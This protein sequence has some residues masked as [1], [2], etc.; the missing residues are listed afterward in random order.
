VGAVLER[1][2]DELREHL[3]FGRA[4]L[5]SY[6]AGEDTVRTVVEQGPGLGPDEVVPLDGFPLL[7][8]ALADRRAVV[9]GD[10]RGGGTLVAAPLLVEGRCLGFA[11]ADRSGGELAL[12]ERELHLLTTLGLVAGILIEKASQQLALEDAVEELRRLDQVKSEFISIA[13]H[14]LRAPIAVVHGIAA[15][16]HLRGDQ[17]TAEQRDE[18]RSTMYAQTGKLR[19]LTE[20]LLDLSRIDSGALRIEPCRFRPRESIDALL[21]RIAP[22]RLSDVEVAIDPG[23][24]VETDPNGFERVTGNLIGNALKYGRPPVVVSADADGSFRLVVEDRGEGVPPEL[25]KSMFE[26]FT[27]GERAR[28]EKLGAGLG[29]AIAR[30]FAKALGG[31]LRYEPAKPHGARFVLKLPR[32][33]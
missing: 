20:Q 18:L 21:P 11:L 33:K 23:L 22:D 15:T 9:G 5:L 14:E 8:E 30:S 28:R 32:A 7:Q 26:R 6:D 10:P 4:A 1:V 17:L 24:E 29:L 13:S 2:C 12:D 27:R 16:L 31:E 19:D 25:A 3:G